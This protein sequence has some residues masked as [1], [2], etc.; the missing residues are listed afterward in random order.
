MKTEL[1]ISESSAL[2]I[3]YSALVF[4]ISGIVGFAI[5]MTALHST[6][7]AN[8]DAVK[9]IQSGYTEMYKTLVSIDKRLDRIEQILTHN[10]GE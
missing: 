2:K 3:T 1:S 7:M 6:T 10:K 8:A 4:V 5:W 9:D